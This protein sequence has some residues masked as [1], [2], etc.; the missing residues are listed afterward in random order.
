MKKNH[1]YIFVPL[2]IKALESPDFE[3]VPTK[4][5]TRD[6]LKLCHTNSNGDFNE[7]VLNLSHVWSEYNAVLKDLD[8]DLFLK[9]HDLFE[10]I[11]KYSLQT[12]FDEK[13]AELDSQEQDS[14]KQ[15]IQ[16]CHEILREKNLPDVQCVS[17]VLKIVDEPWQ[18]P[19][20]DK[21][22]EDQETL[23]ETQN[24]YQNE[25]GNIFIERIRIMCS[26]GCEDFWG[27]SSSKNVTPCQMKST[28]LCFMTSGS[29]LWLAK[30][31]NQLS[32]SEGVEFIKRLMQYEKLD[33]VCH[34]MSN[35]HSK[36]GT[37]LL[38]AIHLIMVNFMGKPEV[39]DNFVELCAFWV[40][41]IFSKNKKSNLIQSLG[42]MSN[43]SAH[44]FILIEEI[45]KKSADIDLPFCIDL[46]T[47]ATTISINEF[48]STKI[49][50]E[51]KKKLSQTLCVR[52]LRLA[53]LFNSCRGI[54][55]EC[56]LTAFTLYPTQEL[57]KEIVDLLPPQVR[58]K[59]EVLS[60]EEMEQVPS[61]MD[62]GNNDG[63]DDIIFVKSIK[64][65]SDTELSVVDIICREGE[66]V[67]LSKIQCEDLY[68]LLLGPRQSTLSW[69]MDR[70]EFHDACLDF[71][72]NFET[73]YEEKELT[74]L[75]VDY[76]KFDNLPRPEI[77][78]YCGIE[79]GYEIFLEEEKEE[80]PLP[81]KQRKKTYESEGNDSTEFDYL[82]S[83]SDQS[84]SSGSNKTKHKRKKKRHSSSD[85]D[86]KPSSKKSH[87]DKKLSKK[88]PK[89]S[90]SE[91]TEY[92]KPSFKPLVKPKPVK[93]L[94]ALNNI[95]K[96]RVPSKMK[97]V[98]RPSLVVKP[99]PKEKK[100]TPS[101]IPEKKISLLRLIR[102]V[103]IHNEV[104]NTDSSIPPQ[105]YEVTDKFLKTV[106]ALKP[107][108]Y[109]Q[110]KT[111]EITS[112]RYMERDKFLDLCTLKHSNSSSSSIGNN[113]NQNQHVPAVPLNQIINHRNSFFSPL[114]KPPPQVLGKSKSVDQFAG[115]PFAEKMKVFSQS[116]FSNE[117]SQYFTN[118]N[119]SNPTNNNSESNPNSVSTPLS[120]SSIA[121]DIPGLSGPDMLD[122]IK[123]PIVTQTVN[124]LDVLCHKL[125]QKSTNS[126][127]INN[128]TTPSITNSNTTQNSINYLEYE[129]SNG[130]NHH[131]SINKTESNIVASFNL[132]IF[133]SGKHNIDLCPLANNKHNNH[134]HNNNIDSDKNLYTAKKNF[135]NLGIQPLKKEDKSTDPFVSE[136]EIPLLESRDK[137]IMNLTNFYNDA[138]N[139]IDDN[140]ESESSLYD[141]NE[142]SQYESVT[143]LK[144]EP[145]IDNSVL[146]TGNNN[147]I[148][149]LDDA[150]FIF[151]NNL[152][153]PDTVSN[154]LPVKD[155]NSEL[156]I[157]KTT[158]GNSHLNIL[159]TEPA[160][161]LKE[162]STVK[163]INFKPTPSPPSQTDVSS[164]FRISSLEKTNFCS[165]NVIPS[166]LNDPVPSNHT[167][168]INNAINFKYISFPEKSD[169]NKI[170][171]NNKNVKFPIFHMQL[172]E[173]SLPTL[174][175][176][177][178]KREKTPGEEKLN[179]NTNV[180]YLVKDK[181]IFKL[182]YVNSPSTDGSSNVQVLNLHQTKSD[183]PNEGSTTPFKK[184]ITTPTK[185]PHMNIPKLLHF[186]SQRNNCSPVN[187]S[188]VVMKTNDKKPGLN[189]QQDISNPPK[190]SV[191]II[192]QP[193]K[194]PA[195]V[196]PKNLI[197]TFPQ[198]K[199]NS[200][201]TDVQSKSE[202][203]PVDKPGDKKFNM[204]PVCTHKIVLVPAVSETATTQTSPIPERTNPISSTTMMEQV[205]EFESVLEKV[206]Q[207]SQLKE[208]V[209]NDEIINTSFI[210]TNQKTTKSLTAVTLGNILLQPT[211]IAT[212]TNL[213]YTLDKKV[214]TVDNKPFNVKQTP[215]IIAKPENKAVKQTSTNTH[216]PPPRPSIVTSNASSSTTTN[217]TIKP[218][219]KA[220]EDEQTAEKIYKILNSYTEKIKNAPELKNKPAPR[221]RSNPPITNSAKCRKSVKCP[222]KF[223]FEQNSN[224][225]S[226]AELSNDSSDKET[227]TVTGT[228]TV[229]PISVAKVKDNLIKPPV[230]I[231][232]LTMPICSTQD[233]QVVLLTNDKHIILKKI[234]HVQKLCQ[235]SP[236]VKPM[237]K[238]D[239]IV[240][241]IGNTQVVHYKIRNDSMQGINLINYV[242]SVDV[243]SRASIITTTMPPPPPISL[244]NISSNITPYKV[245]KL[246]QETQTDI[247]MECSPVATTT[248]LKTCE[249][250][251]IKEVPIVKVESKPIKLDREVEIKDLSVDVDK[252]YFKNVDILFSTSLIFLNYP[253][254]QLFMFEATYALSRMMRTNAVSSTLGKQYTSR[255]M[256]ELQT[257]A[258]SRLPLWEKMK[259][260]DDIILKKKGPHICDT[261]MI[262]IKKKENK[263]P[264]EISSKTT[265]EDKIEVNK[266]NKNPKCYGKKNGI[267]ENF[268]YTKFPQ[269]L[270]PT[271]IITNRPDD[272]NDFDMLDDSN[273]YR[274]PSK[275]DRKRLYQELS[276][277]N[278]DEIEVDNPKV[279]IPKKKRKS[280]NTVST[281][282][283]KS[284]NSKRNL[285][286]TLSDKTNNKASEKEKRNGRVLRTIKTKSFKASIR[287]KKLKHSNKKMM[288]RNTL[289]AINSKSGSNQFFGNLRNKAQGNDNLKLKKIDVSTREVRARRE[290][291]KVR[292]NKLGDLNNGKNEIK[293]KRIRE[294]VSYSGKASKLDLKAIGSENKVTTRQAAGSHIHKSNDH[295]TIPNQ[296]ARLIRSRRRNL[297]T[298][299]T[300]DH[301][302]PERKLNSKLIGKNVSCLPDL[303][304]TTNKVAKNKIPEPGN[305]TN[306]KKSGT[307]FLEMNGGFENSVN[308]CPH[309]QD[310]IV[311]LSATINSQT[312]NRETR[313]LLKFNNDEEN[314]ILNDN[315]K[316]LLNKKS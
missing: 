12:I 145:I 50:K 135:H 110:D 258:E 310:K 114:I 270:E 100:P 187:V 259:I 307:D 92:E 28:K 151:Q 164:K 309:S 111:T 228:T 33:K 104:S 280:G 146:D 212:H 148:N 168:V 244:N 250:Q 235:N 283:I 295:Q 95:A 11:F 5:V 40:D 41:R 292:V 98:L 76:S 289:S 71:M 191:N 149:N 197:V 300:D 32:S 42:D 240:G 291:D 171:I 143:V 264:K 200:K 122:W 166:S 257:F 44:L 61:S 169:T 215:I 241:N 179:E 25:E 305:L 201:A 134:T 189:N 276:S 31:L 132:D 218:I 176:N 285:S 6:F 127:T 302:S 266:C 17:N 277:I 138:K 24:Y 311:E 136:P 274:K 18:N 152:D 48:S 262:M 85:S 57:L 125:D 35:V 206:K 9:S 121:L 102:K 46:F 313:G 139:Q 157:K 39:D 153:V 205:R 101:V 1:G 315:S 183:K 128:L 238:A 180:K 60:D 65:H 106:Q 296:N 142:N 256:N 56:L 301:K 155:N 66:Q 23:D 34:Y 58:I 154:H 118:L 174:K 123:P 231:K 22:F 222:S 43:S 243:N 4:D 54:K 246:A 278:F 196:G 251:V 284:E 147:L 91:N 36:I 209:P 116:Y 281:S 297:N 84:E 26:S 124:V 308:S 94:S 112:Q 219:Q 224:S 69:S 203:L 223:T 211:K 108:N 175:V 129:N 156:F 2:E 162:R 192:Y 73:Q 62:C 247:S 21:M 227:S 202:S 49:S 299:T 77:D 89:K 225:S 261:M 81:P 181:N 182:L 207:T 99:T 220:Q 19:E 16:S 82:Y 221:R 161:T 59:Q 208:K 214:A 80:E 72:K 8:K 178:L 304:V 303:A 79:K 117:I 107:E 15:K 216:F 184:I 141:I 193:T 260:I 290:N 194:N 316:K 230:Q 87:K 314:K 249:T 52:F 75:K 199:I 185:S 13:W 3:V 298:L 286:T 173:S 83:S 120:N 268:K 10:C 144:T 93:D 64:Q 167:K 226:N 237:L 306:S 96:Q 37:V 267:N 70:K 47:R 271:V 74:Y 78:E 288:L 233:N 150:V 253:S 159:K 293:S 186:D 312:Y 27:I 51:E 294:S 279:A 109:A 269:P 88:I 170:V 188:K 163:V 140:S 252:H 229:F 103:K 234:K 172:P 254:S 263:K 86:F 133:Q 273:N 130:G 90:Y 232:Q 210:A 245:N 213:I 97:P 14:L 160:Q 38:R 158:E 137:T 287:N 119:K 55:K 195:V 115:E 7:R 30:T 63:S 236:I 282:S 248:V 272:E 126:T 53:E 275:N 45:M 255:Q 204:N 113:T 20:F 105:I 131:V 67:D 217:S 190:Q 29:F 242:P 68:I 265:H 177:D 198:T 239:S 165:P